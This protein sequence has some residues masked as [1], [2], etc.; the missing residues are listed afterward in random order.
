V[1]RSGGADAPIFDLFYSGQ[2]DKV[3]QAYEAAPDRQWSDADLHVVFASA[4]ALDTAIPELAGRLPDPISA[5]QFWEL[6][7]GQAAAEGAEER[8]GLL[9]QPMRL[10]K[11]VLAAAIGLRSGKR[12]FVETGTYIGESLLMIAGLFDQLV[13]VEADPILHSA[14]K[15]LFMD[16]G[17]TN[18]ELSM[19][20]SRSLLQHIDPAFGDESVYFLDAHYSH[21]IT[22]REYGA[23]PVIDEIVT[24]I[25]RSPDA[26]IV[27]DDLR[28]M[29][30]LDGYPTLVDILNAIPNSRRVSI[31]YDQLIIRRGAVLDQ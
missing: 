15:R 27:V 7:E 5:Q 30:G 17:I 28:T 18:V 22:S 29:T 19:G 10:H 21:G 6:F 31:A 1:T 13:S 14:A 3:L 9:R 25:E 4:S 8:I 16:K 2:H 26:V 23:C 12:Y 20:D 24:V 11:S